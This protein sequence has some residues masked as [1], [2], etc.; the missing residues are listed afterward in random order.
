MTRALMLCV[1]AACGSSPGSSGA[2]APG[3]ID[4]TVNGDTPITDG[5]MDHDAGSGSGSGSGNPAARTVIIIPMENKDST[6]IYGDTT[7]AP[8]ING[9]IGSGGIAAHT[10]NFN[11]ELALAL[12][13][14]PHYIW[15]EAGTNA[16]SD[17]TFTTD[18]DSSAANST[19]STEHLATQL[20]TAGRTWTAYAEGITSGTCPISSNFS[21]YAPK[22]SPFV[23]FQDISGATPSA[24]TA[25]C[26]AHYKA[27]TDL[28]GD[29]AG[30]LPNYVFITPDLCDDMHGD[31]LC[32]SGLG[33]STNIAAGD[34]WLKTNLPPL[35]AYTQTHDAT[36]FVVWDEGDTTLNPVPRDRPARQGRHVERG[37]VHAQLDA[38]DRRGAPRHP[39]VVEGVDR[40]RPQRVVRRR[41]RHALTAAYFAAVF[42]T[43]ISSP[44]LP[45]D[46]NTLP[47]RVTTPFRL[48][49]AVGTLATSVNAP[50]ASTLA[51]VSVPLEA[52]AYSMW[53]A[54]A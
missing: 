53:V 25:G 36:I 7:D 14:E 5:M 24:T 2:D 49:S 26:E 23:F 19:S 22:H 18:D 15:M 44:A 30:T 50:A 29:L 47:S 27:F 1:L 46:K 39:G 52:P 13:S 51:I 40:D 35:I 10:T 8:Y 43:T 31:L 6:E 21:E 41:L 4:G 12:P 9:L 28:A 45:C 20:N 33:D 34:A 42:A 32:A 37:L 48:P 16:F 38:Q 54:G 17:H 11:D 3:H